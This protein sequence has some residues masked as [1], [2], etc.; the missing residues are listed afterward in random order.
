MRLLIGLTV[1]LALAGGLAAAQGTFN[2][3]HRGIVGF[4]A[5]SSKP[6]ASPYGG[7][8]YS[9]PYGSTDDDT[10]AN[11]YRPKTYGAP[12]PPKAPGFEPYKPF[13]GGSVYA[14]P[15]SSGAKDCELSVYTNAC[16]R[17]R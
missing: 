5:P 7:S 14:R 10:P 13:T 17:R 12:E 1:S 9:S 15:P 6:F 8:P 3:G 2:N 16:G 11:R 4:G